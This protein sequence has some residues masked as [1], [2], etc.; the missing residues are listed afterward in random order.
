MY[1]ANVINDMSS[2]ISVRPENN[3]YLN[4]SEE[5]LKKKSNAV[6]CLPAEIFFFLPVVIHNLNLGLWV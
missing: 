4:S 3:I 2:S 1:R 5:N 6:A